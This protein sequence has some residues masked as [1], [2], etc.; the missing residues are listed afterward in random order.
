MEIDEPVLI[1]EVARKRMVTSGDHEADEFL[2]R[3]S[4]QMRPEPQR[5]AAEYVTNVEAGSGIEALERELVKYLL[6]YGHCSFDYKEGRNM[7]ACNVAQVIFEE[8]GDDQIEFRNP[9]YAQ[10]MATYREQ[11]SLSGIGVEVPVH[12]FINH[13]DPDVCNR[14]VDILTSDDN[15]VASELWRRKEVHIES[16]AE[17]LAVGVPK[18]V[19]LYK[20]KVIEGWIKEVQ[21]RLHDDLPD[22]EMAALIQR[23][24][25][26][27]RAKV[28]IANKLQRLIL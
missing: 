2:R 26:Y 16:D 9:L 10:I 6:K 19:T 13:S 5:P 3:Q 14:A 28:A 24:T 25:A 17:M 7:V 15:Y 8:L 11:W 22:E 12:L 18:A 20:S 27:N 23:L 21:A 1:A 4:A